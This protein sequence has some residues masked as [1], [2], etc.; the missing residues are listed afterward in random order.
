MDPFTQDAY[1]RIQ[2]FL[3]DLTIVLGSS[4]PATH[5]RPLRNPGNLQ[6]SFNQLGVKHSQYQ[7]TLPRPTRRSQSW[8]KYWKQKSEESQHPTFDPLKKQHKIFVPKA[9]VVRLP[10]INRTTNFRDRHLGYAHSNLVQYDKKATIDKSG[11]TKK[12]S[13]LQLNPGEYPTHL[14]VEREDINHSRHDTL[15]RSDE[16]RLVGDNPSVGDEQL[17]PDNLS[18]LEQSVINENN[19]DSQPN[20]VTIDYQPG[21]D[22]PDSYQHYLLPYQCPTV[23]YPQLPWPDHHDSHQNFNKEPHHNPLSLAHSLDVVYNNHSHED[24]SN[25]FQQNC[26][27][28][29]NED[30]DF[31]YFQQCCFDYNNHI[32]NPINQ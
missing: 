11:D 25:D 5:D 17:V 22:I 2:L 20:L 21:A 29:Y 4:L 1:R 26:S 31:E 3:A 27:D 24:Y 14:V 32:D 7:T 15:E 10:P 23:C 28:P 13:V 12:N 16:E 19:E 9:A 8:K 18:V 30:D 6:P